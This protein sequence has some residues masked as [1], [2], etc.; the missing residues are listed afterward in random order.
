MEAETTARERSLIRPTLFVTGFC[1]IGIELAA[2]RLVAPYFGSS[3][4]IWANLIGLTLSFLALGYYLGGKLADRRP[5]P[6]LLYA[7]LI[8]AAVATALVPLA[9]HPILRASLAAF[10]NVAVGAFYGSL[11]GTL[12]LLAIP[13]TLI[14]AATPFAV[15]L[16]MQSVASAGQTTGGLYAL[17]T[18]GS[19]AGSFVPVLV[20]IPFLGTRA[21]FFI[22]GGTLGAVAVLGLISTVGP[23]GSAL[24]LLLLGLTMVGSVGASSGRIKPPYRGVLVHEEESAYNY[25]QVLQ[26]GDETIL[27]L[28]EGHAIHSIYNPTSLLT[29]GPWDYLLVAPLFRTGGPT[30]TRRAAIIGL[31]AGTS[32]RQLTAAYPDIQID[33]V[34]IDPAVVDVGR[35]WFDMNEPNLRV[36]IE[37]GRYF[38]RTTTSTYD[39]IAIDAYH[40]PYIPF[41]LT[42]T[43]FFTDVAD[44]LEPGGVAVVNA[45][46]TET[47]FRLVDAI[48]ATMSRVFDHVF[49]IDADRFTNTIVFGMNDAASTDAFVA[50]AALLPPGPIRT[51]AEASL[52][53]GRVREST[54]TGPVFRDDRAPVEWVTDQIIVDAARNGDKP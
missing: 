33:G 16:E 36:S 19:I 22:L 4:F 15:R 50:N 46:R 1:G 12:L 26:D 17:S 37:D 42:T 25:I 38:M 23:R 5:E 40:Q 14:G 20:L 34:E 29:G 54:A 43:E 51:V 24:A 11:V 8:L 41:Q 49:L 52:S 13:V 27:A 35:R 32:A 39:V 28:N 48:S 2:S 31:A 7:L 10:D 30:P 44:H 47:D 18:V 53:T 45:G 6:A 9:S 21:T 3:T